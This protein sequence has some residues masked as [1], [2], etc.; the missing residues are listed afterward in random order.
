MVLLA[1][2]NFVPVLRRSS[3]VR[4]PPEAWQCDALDEEDWRLLRVP[5]RVPDN[6]ARS[7]P[8]VH[9]GPPIEARMSVCTVDT[10]A[11]TSYVAAARYCQ[12]HRRRPEN[13]GH[14]VSDYGVIVDKLHRCLC[15]H[16]K[17]HLERTVCDRRR[18]R[19][20][21]F[22]QFHSVHIIWPCHGA[23]LIAHM[24]PMCVGHMQSAHYIMVSAVRHIFGY[25]SQ[26]ILGN[27]SGVY[28][29]K[30]WHSEM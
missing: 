7:H 10:A 15:V 6:R 8:V 13:A 3:T 25:P 20:I 27:M 29:R 17:C 1:S 16:H 2:H 22:V 5:P 18:H 12:N 21:T 26:Y 28:G 14:G 23:L 9:I 4:V 11:Y 24:P 19:V 30:W